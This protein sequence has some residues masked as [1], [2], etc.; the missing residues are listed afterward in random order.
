MNIQ[1]AFY[2]GRIMHIR[3]VLTALGPIRVTKAMTAFD[4]GQ[5]NWSEC[6]FARAF[7]GELDLHRNPEQQI[8]AAIGLKSIVPIRFVWRSFDS[9]RETGMTRA[10]LEKLIK[11]IM[12]QQHSDA[13]EK[14]LR[15]I[16]FDETV[17]V[18]MT[19]AS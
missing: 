15:S 17:P 14:F 2:H 11:E 3:N 7:Q 1:D 13:A 5:S 9:A 18:E 6:F 8:K 16:E 19:C 4:D 12:T 10:T